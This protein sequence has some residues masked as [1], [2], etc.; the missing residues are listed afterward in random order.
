MYAI[1]NAIHRS[2]FT[3]LVLLSYQENML[4]SLLRIY[5]PVQAK[6]L[7]STGKPPKDK[8]TSYSFRPTHLVKEPPRLLMSA[9]NLLL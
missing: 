2:K 8:N 7:V 9:Y 3:S 6:Q 4:L 1:D 5:D